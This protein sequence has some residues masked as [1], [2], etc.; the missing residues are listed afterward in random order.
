MVDFNSNLG[1]VLAPSCYSTLMTL[2]DPRFL[3]TMVF[4]EASPGQSTPLN[5]VAYDSNFNLVDSKTV[6][7]GP[8]PT[9]VNLGPGSAPISHVAF[10]HVGGKEETA[11][12]EDAC[13]EP[14]ITYVKACNPATY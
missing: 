6:F 7:G 2:P 9:P 10:H 14:I 4:Q 3:V 8:T 13:W 5:F 11:C 1:H 12:L